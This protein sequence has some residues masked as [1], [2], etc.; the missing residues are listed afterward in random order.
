MT[1]KNTVD[2]KTKLWMETLITLLDRRTGRVKTQR[3]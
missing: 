3:L 2:K 1:N